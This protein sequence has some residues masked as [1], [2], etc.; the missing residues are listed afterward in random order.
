MGKRD[1]RMVTKPTDEALQD[2]V[3]RLLDEGWAVKKTDSGP[4]FL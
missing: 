4:Q 1:Y 3:T 2:A